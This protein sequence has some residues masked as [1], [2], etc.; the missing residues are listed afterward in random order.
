VWIVCIII[1]IVMTSRTCNQTRAAS[2][3]GAENRGRI[4]T[5]TAG[6][7]AQ[8]PPCFKISDLKLNPL[9]CAIILIYKMAQKYF[10]S[11]PW[12]LFLA[13][14]NLLTTRKEINKNQKHKKQKNVSFQYGHERPGTSWNISHDNLS[15]YRSAPFT[16]VFRVR[17]NR[18]LALWYISDDF[19]SF[20]Y[21]K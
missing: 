5:L 7:W 4:E 14:R 21:R 19:E 13:K 6:D 15:F 9:Q 11:R 8:G 18:E 20:F 2:R 17:R 12:T 16:V 10:V 1:K 3:E